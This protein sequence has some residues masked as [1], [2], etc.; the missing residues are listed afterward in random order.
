MN[1][2][3]KKGQGARRAA[4]APPRAPEHDE[5]VRSLLALVDRD[6]ASRSRRRARLESRL[7]GAIRLL[8]P[9]RLTGVELDDAAA[10]VGI[11]SSRI[12]AIRRGM[13][14]EHHPPAEAPP[15]PE[16]PPFA[17]LPQE[18]KKAIREAR[19][20]EVKAM[21]ASSQGTDPPTITVSELSRRLTQFGWNEIIRVTPNALQAMLERMKGKGFKAA[22]PAPGPSG[23]RR[24]APRAGRAAK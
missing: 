9:E 24:G 2:T 13:F 17:E 15:L 3:G 16:M 22:R 14:K 6:V 18:A 21:L 20:E 4:G 19:I 5:V 23:K 11:L 10:L 8:D 7:R 12:D 1:T